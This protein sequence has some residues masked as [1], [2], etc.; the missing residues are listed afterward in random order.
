MFKA[1]DNLRQQ[2]GFTLIELLIVVAIIGILAAIA[3][4][5][6]IGMQERGRK[7]AVV[8][9]AGGAE[10][11]LQA[12][13]SSSLKVGPGAALIECD[14]NWD[15]TIAAPDL[16]NS[17]AGSLAAAGVAVTYVAARNLAGTELSPWVAATPLWALGAA[18]DPAPGACA[19]ANRGQIV[20]G[21]TGNQIS[22]TGCD[23]DAVA[24]NVIHHKIVSAD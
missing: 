18:L 20:V 10:A 17:G 16:P 6:Y 21:Q 9:G 11:D 12:W 3:I 24:P 22:I 15:G 4:P 2:K 23:G 19:V 13:L 7:G 5:G 8:R 1:V 14:T